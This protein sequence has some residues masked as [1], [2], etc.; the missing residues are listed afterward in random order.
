MHVLK[1]ISMQKTRGAALGTVVA[2]TLSVAIASGQAPPS[3]GTKEQQPFTAKYIMTYLDEVGRTTTFTGTWYRRADGAI[4]HV[5]E[6]GGPLG[7]PGMDRDIFN[8]ADRSWI[9]A[10]SFTATSTA[11]LH[12]IMGQFRSLVDANFGTCTVLGDETVK[13]V[14]ES[15]FLGVKV[16]ELEE[17]LGR[18]SVMRRT[19]APDLGCFSLQ[20][21]D[22][23][24]GVVRTITQTTQLNF[25]EP[26]EEAFRVPDGY[27][28]VSPLEFNARWRGLFGHDF[29]RPV[30][31]QKLEQEYQQGKERQR[32]LQQRNQ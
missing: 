20:T 18:A 26:D 6:T 24:S 17:P 3:P 27:A 10:T 31:A 16:T 2:L 1:G 23:D 7:A 12:L 25:G 9:T 32:Q 19:V 21:L 5:R 15:Q 11:M 30:Q 22:I 8:P 13:H 28:E 14:G 29:F 4:S